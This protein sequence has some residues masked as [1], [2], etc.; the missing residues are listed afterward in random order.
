M[1]P[2]RPRPWIKWYRNEVETDTT[3]T[4]LQGNG[5]RGVLKVGP[6]TRSDVRATLTCRASNHLR[7]HPIET[8]LTLDMNCKLYIFKHFLKCYS[9]LRKE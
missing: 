6:L 7:A 3:A 4:T 5:V 8:T 9:T 1:F 2:G